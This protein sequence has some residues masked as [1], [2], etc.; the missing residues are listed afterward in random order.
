MLVAG[1]LG[2]QTPPMAVGA[3]IAISGGLLLALPTA[4]GAAAD[5]LW[6]LG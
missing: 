1:Q 3:L 4:P 2:L 6:P 5:P